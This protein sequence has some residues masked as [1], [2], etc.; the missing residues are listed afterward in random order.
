MVL[1]CDG[2]IICS[3]KWEEEP[4]QQVPPPDGRLSN[5]LKLSCCL[6]LPYTLWDLVGW[7]E[8]CWGIF[9]MYFEY[10][11]YFT[12]QCVRRKTSGTTD[13]PHIHFHQQMAR[14]LISVTSNHFIV[15][16][17]LTHADPCTIHTFTAAGYCGQFVNEQDVRLDE[18]LLCLLFS[19]VFKEMFKRCRQILAFHE[20]Q[21]KQTSG[22]FK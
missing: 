18:R 21:K 12:N 1:L 22:T 5:Q 16:L 9:H 14:A 11:K 4:G 13:T 17:M 6:Y 10:F 3:S 8:S 20:I 19:S 15:K 2:D 7:N